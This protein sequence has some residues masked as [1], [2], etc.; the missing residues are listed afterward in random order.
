MNKI[1]QV[2][3]RKFDD[4]V[5]Q[6]LY[7]RGV[8]KVE[9]DEEAKRIFFEPDFA[10]NLH[11]PFLMKNLAKA[12]D[13]IKLAY[14]NKEKI[15]IFADYDADGVPGAALF[16]R[17]L[18]QIGIQCEVY[19]PSRVEGYGLSKSGLDFLKEKKCEL[20]ITIDLGIRSFAEAE[21]AKKIGLDLIITDHHLP[22]EKIP[23][24]FLV[25]NPKQPGDN[26][27][28]KDLCGCAVA[29]KLVQGLGKV[30]PKGLDEKFLKWNLDLVA[31]STISDVVPLSDENRIIAQFGL[32]VMRKSHNLGLA[33]LIKIANLDPKNIGAYH[34]GFQ[35]GPRI[36]APG[37]MGKATKSFELLVTE[38][39]KEAKELA[40]WLNS[41]NE[42]RQA[43]M[44]TTEKEADEYIAENKLAENK[45]I[46]LR[47]K[48]QKGVIGPTASR[49]VEKYSRPVIL[50]AEE[51]TNLVGSARSV[52]GV[53]I[54]EL[55]S[56]AKESIEKF[57]GHA[58]AAGLSIK[59]V[60]WQ[61]FQ[62]KIAK[63]AEEK[64]KDS[65]LVKKVKIDAEVKLPELSKKLYEKLLRFEP[66][67]MGNPRPT[68]MTEKVGFENIRFVGRD[69][70]H[71]QARAVD[72]MEKIKLI[73]FSFPYDKS[74]ITSDQH[75][76][77]AFTLN[78]DE[79]NGNSELCL[80]IIDLKSAHTHSQRL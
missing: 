54:L 70:N 1:W 62:T 47:G 9:A 76:D 21:Y 69:Q 71:F 53:H 11:D 10:K 56:E 19:I 48:W 61:K 72:E 35:I 43:A 18:K 73:H 28:N 13:R 39:E 60:N 33:E 31:I 65:D 2:S 4:L 8:I 78:L 79:W 26:Y 17:A 68:F 49:L 66:F 23:E 14:E 27:P 77:I 7:N 75:Y 41:E 36:N 25:I 51:G 37:R 6:L 3:P 44:D 40:Q 12:V 50:F 30:F 20:V 22:D 29:F 34:V 58:G 55:L 24:A 52:S 46:I 59:S 38:D 45:V 15:G 74:M 32:I 5:D 16:Y 64:I 42:S 67:G 63:V 80:H 57:G